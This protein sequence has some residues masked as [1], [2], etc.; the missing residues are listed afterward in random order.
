MLSST[1]M[2]ALAAEEEN[3]ELYP[4]Q[5]E[6]WLQTSKSQQN[7]DLLAEDPNLIFLWAG[8]GFAKDYRSP[9]GH[10]FA[11]TD[12]ISSLRTGAPKEDN[13]AK[14]MPATCWTCKSPDVPRII[15]QETEFGF[16]GKKFAEYGQQIR[17]SVGCQDCHQNKS[18]ELALTR[19]HSKR[20]VKELNKR[21]EEQST[22]MKASMVC[23]QCHSE[24]Y[25]QK[26][27][28]TRVINPWL[29]GISAAQQKLYYDSRGYADWTHPVSNAP[30]LKAQHP[31]FETWRLSA[32]A[33]K[34]VGCATC[35]M[36]KMNSASGQDYSLHS[37][38]NPLEHFETV[39]QEC[40]ES[41]TQMTENIAKA[42]HEIGT[43]KREV[44][45]LL[46]MVHAEAGAIQKAGKTPEQ[47]SITLDYIRTAQ[48]YW[49]Y[50]IASHGIHVHNPQL[51]INL[52]KQARNIVTFARYPLLK[53]IK[54]TKISVNYPDLSTKKAAQQAI[55]LDEVELRRQ[56][57]EFI[58]RVSEQGWAVD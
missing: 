47:M 35:H 2:Q 37:L 52:L 46:V 19:P 40:H 45:S 5:Y 20:A 13:Q 7:R 54:A 58:E 30:M 39:C 53:E 22:A 1:S 57:Q 4:Q 12:I 48:W 55:G 36:P 28:F 23:G 10:S 44:G 11:V 3:H 26:H 15:A 25:F 33:T 27:M 31:E 16:T 50:A 56:K 9:R 29:F 17:Y 41:K 21:F 18:A 14:Q 43:L 32:H 42:K 24:Y 49:D 34:D 38:P 6:S 8:Y 51:A